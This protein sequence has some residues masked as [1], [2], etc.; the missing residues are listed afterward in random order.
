MLV[1]VCLL[2]FSAGVD[3]FRS[4]RGDRG[5]QSSWRLRRLSFYGCAL[6][7]RARGNRVAPRALVLGGTAEFH[8]RLL[9]CVQAP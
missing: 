7:C 5:V 9:R 2:L 8:R 1:L 6:P 4:A 3:S